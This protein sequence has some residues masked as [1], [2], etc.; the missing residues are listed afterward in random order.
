MESHKLFESAR[1]EK[2]AALFLLAAAIFVGLQAVN[3]LMKL[4]EPRPAYGN[5]ITVEGMGKVTAVPD[6]AT[7]TFSI[8]EEATTASAAQDS[9]AKKMNVALA[10]LTDELNIPEADIKTTSYTVYPRYNQPQPCYREFCPEYDQRIVGYTASQSVEVKVRE[11]DKAGEVLSK[12]GDAGVSNL[13]GPSFTIDDPEGLKAEARKQAIEDARAKA[14][15]LAKDLNVR[16]V[17]VTGFWENSGG[18]PT[19]YYGK[20][21]GMG[22]DMAVSS[23]SPEL[24]VG[25]NDIQVMVSVSYEIR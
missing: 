23:V 13:Y 8:S 19:P 15:A 9:A 10:V 7:V 1:V 18:Y 5:I 11:T 16:I 2:L 3:A 17:R 20:A 6:V 12:L 21:E 14:K 25:E 4:F 24:P 22:G